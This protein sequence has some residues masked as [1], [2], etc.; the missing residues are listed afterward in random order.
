MNFAIHIR[1]YVLM[2]RFILIFLGFCLLL[3]SSCVTQFSIKKAEEQTSKTSKQEVDQRTLFLQGKEEQ[4]RS[5][6]IKFLE[7]AKKQIKEK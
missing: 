2:N 6:F 5:D 3:L 7:E 1:G 4:I